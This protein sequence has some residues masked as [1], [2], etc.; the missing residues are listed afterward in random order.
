MIAI[1]KKDGHTVARGLKVSLSRSHG[2]HGHIHRAFETG[3]FVL[4]PE[5]WQ[6]G[7]SLE[8]GVYHMLLENGVLA[9]IRIDKFLMQDGYL[10]AA[11]AFEE[12]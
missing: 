2:I 6:D 7:L 4:P 3:V 1:L 5:R 10:S 9:K 8:G 11:F 12:A